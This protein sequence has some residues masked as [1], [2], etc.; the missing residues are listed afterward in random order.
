MLRRVYLRAAGATNL[1]LDRYL[2]ARVKCIV[3][4][5]PKIA[6]SYRTLT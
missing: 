5:P 3:M 6:L 1:R 4:I 2:A